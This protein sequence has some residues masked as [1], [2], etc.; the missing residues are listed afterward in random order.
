MLT[1]LQR[2]VFV[3]VE[4]ICSQ[5][6]EIAPLPAILDLKK[7]YPFRILLEE[8]CSIGVLGKSGRGALEHFQLPDADV[9]VRMASLGTALGSTGGIAVGSRIV[10]DHMRLNCTGYV[11]SCSSPPYLAAAA[12]RSLELLEQGAELAALRSNVHFFRSRYSKSSLHAVLVTKSDPLNPQITFFLAEAIRKS[13]EEDEAILDAI[14]RA[15]LGS[16]EG[17]PLLLAVV[18]SSSLE[19]HRSPPAVRFVVSAKHTREDLIRA[20]GSLSSRTLRY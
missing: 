2:R 12:V 4:A 16:A 8:S 1:L 20:P 13:R 5:H 19:R 6:G 10:C 9:E 18:R 7:R 15:C 17:L 11:F 14:A 3:V